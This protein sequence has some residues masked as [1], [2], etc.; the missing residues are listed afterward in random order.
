[1]SKWGLIA[2]LGSVSPA[3]FLRHLLKPPLVE[4]PGVEQPGQPAISMTAHRFVHAK[5][6]WNLPAVAN[7][8]QFVSMSAHFR[9]DTGLFV[10][11]RP[12]PRRMPCFERV[13]LGDPLPYRAMPLV[14]FGQ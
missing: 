11:N 1:M 8:V 14:E 10:V 2:E 12:E 13:D 7:S 5:Q 9:I 6:H 3:I 4:A